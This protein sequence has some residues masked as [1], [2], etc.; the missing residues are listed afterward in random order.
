M[1]AYIPVL[2]K[3]AFKDE[4]AFANTKVVTTLFNHGLEGQLGQNFKKTLEYKSIKGTALSEFNNEFDYTE[5]EKLAIAY[6]DGVI[7]GSEG[8][9]SVLTEYAEQK[10]VPMLKYPGQDFTEPYKKFY[11]VIYPEK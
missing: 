2:I 8:I 3:K 9:K 5:L 1:A 11:E 7:E 4:P 10:A 6:S